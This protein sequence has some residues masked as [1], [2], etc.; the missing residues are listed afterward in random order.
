MKQLTTLISA[1]FLLTLGVSQSWALPNCVGSYS[2]TVWDNCV[3]TKIY[4]DGIKYVGEYKDGKRNGHGTHTHTE[5]KEK[6]VGGWKDDMPHG[7]GTL[8]IQRGGGEI[9]DL[10]FG[11]GEEKIRR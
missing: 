8:T 7:H 6:Y 11:V 3:G 10:I 4:A 1:L 9:E 5:S 2:A